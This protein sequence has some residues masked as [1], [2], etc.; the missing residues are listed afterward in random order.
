VDV[1]GAPAVTRRFSPVAR[2][3]L[4]TEITWSYL[5]VRNLLRRRDLP[6]T[7]AVLR[8]HRPTPDRPAEPDLELR[9]ARAVALTL[10]RLPA[11]TRCLAQSLV[12]TRLLAVRGI[13]TTLVIGVSEPGEEFGAHAWVERDGVPLLPV[14]GAADRRLV[15]L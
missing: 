9:L 5:C 1:T 8:Q 13:A 7:L 4:A 3:R 12:L 2:A 11:D 15:E 10:N 14:G 6:S